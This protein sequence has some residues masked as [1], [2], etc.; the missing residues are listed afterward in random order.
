MKIKE[1]KPYVTKTQQTSNSL[2]TFVTTG[3]TEVR[4]RRNELEKALEKTVEIVKK[5]KTSKQKFSD[6]SVQTYDEFAEI[7][8]SRSSSDKEIIQFRKIEQENLKKNFD[9][10]YKLLLEKAEKLGYNL[11]KKK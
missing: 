4:F 3:Y 9:E 11:V 1:V 5:L 6:I 10:E 8:W 2:P 7:S